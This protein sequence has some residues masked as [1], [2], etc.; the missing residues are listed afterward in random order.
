MRLPKLTTV[1]L[2]V[3]QF[4]VAQPVSET[5]PQM[6]DNARR[7]LDARSYMKGSLVVFRLIQQAKVKAAH[8]SP[9]NAFIESYME[10]RNASQLSVRKSLDQ[11]QQSWSAANWDEALAKL[12][13][14]RAGLSTLENRVPPEEKYA[15][16]SKDAETSP[17]LGS[18]NLAA[19]S[20]WEAN[21]NAEAIQWL[22]RVIAFRIAGPRS[23]PLPP[24]MLNQAFTFKGMIYLSMEDIPRALDAL[25]SSAA[26]LPVPPFNRLRPSMALAKK[27]LELGQKEAVLAYFANCEKWNWPEGTEKLARWRSEIAAGQKP[28]FDQTDLLSY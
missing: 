16:D 1:V 6:F 25:A 4:C 8:E 19:R 13:L 14:A 5:P 17:S 24:Q 28:S 3:G 9:K 10:A 23:F 20:A 18:L 11:A 12:E 2:L 21:R 7:E 22:D 26:G 27:L 15:R